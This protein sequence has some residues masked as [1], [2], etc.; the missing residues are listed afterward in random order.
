MPFL[1]LSAFLL[2]KSF[3]VFHRNTILY[4]VAGLLIITQ[5]G[6]TYVDDELSVLP[7]WL[8]IISLDAF[9]LS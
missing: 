7:T 5:Y 3:L 8:L 9:Y 2:I 6:M 4:T 1:V